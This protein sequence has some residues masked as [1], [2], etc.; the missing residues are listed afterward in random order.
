MI[1]HNI[2]NNQAAAENYIAAVRAMKD[3]TGSP[4]PGQPGLSMYDFFVFWH[5][6]A[7]MLSTPLTQRDRNAAH[8]GPVFLPWHRYMLLMLEFFMRQALDQDD[9]RIPYWDWAGDAELPIPSQSPLWSQALLGQFESAGFQVRL[10]ANPTASNPRQVSRRLQR[11]VGRAGRLSR[12]FELRELVRD[13]NIYDL[14]P[15][16]RSVGAFRNEC[17]GWEGAGHHNLV[18]VFVGGDMQSSTSPNDPVFFLVHANVDRLWEAWRRRH[19]TSQYLPPQTASEE[20]RF[21]R[22][23]DAMHTFFDHG[24]DVTPATMIDPSPWYQYDR[25][26]DLT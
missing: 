18:H 14:P 25:L 23:G 3:P 15:Y 9:F 13:R 11:T 7:M 5:H 21:H 12:R 6:Q 26:D 24:F 20:L 22:I 19:P 1:R 4:W 2:L 17:E 8:S 10:E 16:D